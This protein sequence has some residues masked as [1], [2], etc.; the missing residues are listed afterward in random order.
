M[1]PAEDGD[2]FLIET[3]PPCHRI[4]IDGGRKAT[5]RGPLRELLSSL[6]SQDGPL[7]DLVVLTHIDADHIEGL[8]ELIGGPEARTVGEVWFNGLDQ[9]RA[10]NGRPPV[11]RPRVVPAGRK[12]LP[13]LSVAQLA[14]LTRLLQDRGCICNGSLPGRAAMV[15]PEGELPSIEVSSGAKITLLGPPRAKLGQLEARWAAALSELSRQDSQAVLGPKRTLP[16]PTPENVAQLARDRDEADKK[17]ENGTSIVLTIEHSGKRALF[18]ADAHP[19]DVAAALNRF[20]PGS[21]RVFFDAVK[22]AHHGSAGNN[23]AMLIDRLKSP[24]W[25]VS[26][27]GAVHRLPDPEGIA[28]IALTPPRD[29]RL[30]FNYRTDNVNAVWA[31]EALARHCGYTPVFP[32]KQGE[33]VWVWL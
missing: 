17:L 11:P 6:P 8:L 25:L 31:D 32:T 10:A 13:V 30:L 21:G 28:R 4:L 5:A 18:C 9:A 15:E 16:V 23:T 2:C 33:L 3:G 27:N 24:V 14:D 29:K 26:S 12:R 7:L 22:V 20:S 19:G 1:L